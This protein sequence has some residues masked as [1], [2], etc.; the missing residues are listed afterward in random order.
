MFVVGSGFCTAYMMKVVA[1]Y[2]MSQTL[3]EKGYNAFAFPIPSWKE[4][5]TI[6]SL[7][8]PVKGWINYFA[9]LLPL[10]LE[11]SNL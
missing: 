10:Y 8:A 5:L 11:L 6:L 4:F 7:L 1:A 9:I 2:I 3:N